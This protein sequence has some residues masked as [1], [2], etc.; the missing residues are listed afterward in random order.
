MNA[1]ASQRVQ[2]GTNRPLGNSKKKS[3]TQTSP[4]ICTPW[5][6][7]HQAG[8]EETKASASVVSTATVPKVTRKSE[9]KIAIRSSERRE[10]MSEPTANHTSWKILSLSITTLKTA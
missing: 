1:T 10:K 5:T 9:V 4:T 8:C 7:S 2:W 3:T 6:G